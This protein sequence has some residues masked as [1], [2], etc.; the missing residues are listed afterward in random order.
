MSTTTVSNGARAGSGK[1]LDELE[2]ALLDP[3]DVAFGF[4]DEHAARTA[5]A[6]DAVRN[7]RREKVDMARTVGGVTVG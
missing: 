4:D 5:D 2:A 1:P 3:D 6:A 7:V